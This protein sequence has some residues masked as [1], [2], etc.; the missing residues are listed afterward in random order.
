MYEL[1]K[2]F[3]KRKVHY[4]DRFRNGSI[5]DRSVHS[6][7]GSEFAKMAAVDCGVPFMATISLCVQLYKLHYARL[8]K[9]SSVDNL[10]LYSISRTLVVMVSFCRVYHFLRNKKNNRI[11]YFKEIYYND[12]RKSNFK[13]MCTWKKRNNTCSL[14]FC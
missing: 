10:G 8:E 14:I 12:E 3:V 11:K 9:T 7:N 2:A 4:F 5:F 13:W 6:C 1:L